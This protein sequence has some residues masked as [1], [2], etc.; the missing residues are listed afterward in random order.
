MEMADLQKWM[1][2]ISFGIIAVLIIGNNLW[3]F[4][5]SK[6]K[7]ESTS[8][9][10]FIGAFFGVISCLAAPIQ[11]IK[12]LSFIPVLIDPGTSLVV[13][14]IFKKDHENK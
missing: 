14:S 6:I 10:I 11:P 7:N 9:T 3:H 13:Y 5:R 4:F 2:T 1:Y 12:W 8:Y